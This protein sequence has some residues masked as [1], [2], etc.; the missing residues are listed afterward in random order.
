L[1]LVKQRTPANSDDAR[2]AR[3]REVLSVEADAIHRLRDRLG[4]SFLRAV[5][6]I[7]GCKGH[8]IVTGMGK[9]GKIAEKISATFASTGTPSIFLHPAEA[10][11]GDLG[12]CL[13]SDVMLTLSN[14]GFTEEILRLIP[15][16]KQI[17]ATLIA[18][19]SDP[20]SP[21]SR[22][23]DLTLDLG[24]IA[25]A[26][27]LGLAPTASTAAM[28]AL[29]DALAMV[30]LE[31][32]GFTRDD[33]ALF[34][35]AGSLGLQLMRVRDRMRTGDALPLVGVGTKVRD[36]LS[37]MH[38]KG[39]AG[40]A[41]VVDGERKLLGIFT[42]GDLR[43]LLMSRGGALLDDAVE[44]VMVRTPKTIR[45]DALAA[46][47]S[48]FLHEYQIDQLPVVDEAGRAVGLLD[49]QD[50]LGLPPG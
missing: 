14:S 1:P 23:A 27:P 36:T 18:V 21:L 42:D 11:H 33:F 29:G 5:D 10:V 46:E 19:T 28:L 40:A 34:H 41:L 43:R 7:L 8:V 6:T 45:A 12:R 26:C 22:E 30:V 15:P 32:R 38:T 9:A 44:S 25:E 31:S 17:G 48:R 47:A 49:V 3:A 39:R 13:R 16:V 20:A 37:T 35:P 24:P 50:L 4:E 2:L